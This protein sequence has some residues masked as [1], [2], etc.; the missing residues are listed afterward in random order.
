MKEYGFHHIMDVPLYYQVGD[1]YYKTASKETALGVSPEIP[2]WEELVRQHIMESEQAYNECRRYLLC[3][4]RISL[5]MEN[6][7][8]LPNFYLSRDDI[9]EKTRKAL[10]EKA[11]KV[12][13]DDVEDQ[14]EFDEDIILEDLEEMEMRLDGFW[15]NHSDVDGFKIT[16]KKKSI[17][18]M[19][20]NILIKF[21]LEEILP[22]EK[23]IFIVHGRMYWITK[24]ELL[25]E[26]E[27]EDIDEVWEDMP[28]TEEQAREWYLQ[29]D[30]DTSPAE[31]W[32]ERTR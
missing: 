13:E 23:R 26:I 1:Q 28:T 18:E 30:E 8:G 22:P 11:S 10:L 4:G 27:Q 31:E 14:W 25:E 2:G 24:D 7:E 12:L 19:T 6:V 16:I 21:P 20:Y 3:N 17:I 9:P 29:E 5:T 32:D 15:I